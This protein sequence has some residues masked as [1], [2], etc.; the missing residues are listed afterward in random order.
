MAA[1]GH[2]GELQRLSRPPL[3]KPTAWVAG[4]SAGGSSNGI[5]EFAPEQRGSGDDRVAP[6]RNTGAACHLMF[7]ER[8]AAV[9]RPAFCRSAQSGMRGLLHAADTSL[10]MQADRYGPLSRVRRQVNTGGPHR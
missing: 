2:S 7:W 8:N 5:T 10:C 3:L 6:E 4:R 9:R 1:A